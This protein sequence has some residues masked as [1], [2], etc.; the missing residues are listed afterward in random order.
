MRKKGSCPF[1]WQ[2]W[3]EDSMLKKISHPNN[4]VDHAPASSCDV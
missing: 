1:G 3:D 4:R 2:R